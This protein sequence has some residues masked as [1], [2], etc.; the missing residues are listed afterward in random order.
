MLQ[1][2]VFQCSAGLALFRIQARAAKHVDDEGVF[3]KVVQWWWPVLLY[4][5]FGVGVGLWFCGAFIVFDD[6]YDQVDP[7]QMMPYFYL[8][9]ALSQLAAGIAMLVTNFR[10]RRYFTSTEGT[11]AMKAAVELRPRPPPSVEIT[12]IG[13]APPR[14]VGEEEF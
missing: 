11:R 9:A 12:P 4:G 14:Q 3:S 8:I 1:S 13:S 10:V 6:V 2:N 5:T 7:I